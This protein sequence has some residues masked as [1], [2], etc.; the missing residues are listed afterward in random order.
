MEH[1]ENNLASALCKAQA[2]MEAAYEG[3][4]NPH[5]KSSFCR[6]T[7]LINASR[8]SL[9]KYGLSVSQYPDSDADGTYLVTQLLHASGE[10]IVSKVK[11][12]LDKPS[13]IQSFGKVMTYLKR[14]AYAA[15]VGIAIADEQDDDGNSVSTPQTSSTDYISDKQL[16]LLIQKL[17]IKP[18]AE[19]ELIKKYGTLKQIPWKKFNDIICWIDPTMKKN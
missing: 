13:D 19:S 14:Y 9:T 17:P 3:G 12:V 7:D 8:P 16:A 6:L 15:I 4:Y 5:F 1:K 10:K 11:M 2:E 18:E